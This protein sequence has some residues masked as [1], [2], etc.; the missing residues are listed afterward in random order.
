MLRELQYCAA[1]KWLEELYRN[2][3]MNKETQEEFMYS[4]YHGDNICRG[5]LDEL[6]K[7]DNAFAALYDEVVSD[8]GISFVLKPI[9]SP[10]EYYVR[11]VHFTDEVLARSA[12]T[13]PDSVKV[14]GR[15]VKECAKKNALANCKKAISLVPKL[16]GKLLGPSGGME[17]Y[18][19]S[20]NEGDFLKHINNGMWM[21]LNDKT[22]MDDNGEPTETAVDMPELNS[23]LDDTLDD[24]DGG[25]SFDE[26]CG[27]DNCDV[28]TD[29]ENDGVWMPFN[30]VAPIHW[31]FPG[32]VTFVCFGP[33]NGK[34]FS[35]LLN[36]LGNVEDGEEVVVT[37]REAKKTKTSSR[38]YSRAVDAQ[39]A[40]M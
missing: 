20:H 10:N 22:N 23:S 14:A 8:E 21:I 40:R 39:E 7:G 32:F 9:V 5:S 17:E 28:G 13:K 4:H 12:F 26:F 1:F 11:G 25:N 30:G 16:V 36:P 31:L 15:T 6:T 37:G 24:T 34:W 29:V 38:A 18:T 35:S 2:K 3:G 27:A 19:S 33:H